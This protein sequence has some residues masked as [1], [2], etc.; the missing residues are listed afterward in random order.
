MPSTSQPLI[1]PWL[2]VERWFRALDG[3]MIAGHEPWIAQVTAIHAV[4][5]CRWVQLAPRHAPDQSLFLTFS[6]PLTRDAALAALSRYQPETDSPHP[7]IIEV[8]S[9]DPRLSV[10]Q[11][12]VRDSL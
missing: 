3:Q 1:S 5:T 8:R 9:T 11:S 10:L 4:G 2:D 6:E 12:W 7:R